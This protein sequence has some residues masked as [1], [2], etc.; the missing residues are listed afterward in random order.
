M[1]DWATIDN[2]ST[3]AEHAG[4]LRVTRAQGYVEPPQNHCKRGSGNGI[5]QS[6]LKVPLKL[7]RSEIA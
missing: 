1:H 2:M 3:D 5:V 4:A 7:S 6:P